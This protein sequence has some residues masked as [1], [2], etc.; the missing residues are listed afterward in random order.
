MTGTP[1]ANDDSTL[2]AK[3]AANLGA[4]VQPAQEPD[5]SNVYATFWQT[6]SG[7]FNAAPEPVA[8]VIAVPR[9]SDP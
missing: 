9:G 7:F 1:G 4:P 6:Q 3:Q 5:A 2:I 8:G